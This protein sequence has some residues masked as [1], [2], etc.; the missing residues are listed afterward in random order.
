ML[1]AG[2]TTQFY[3]PSGDPRGVRIA[4]LNGTPVETDL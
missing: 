1:A 2:K 3:C 4:K